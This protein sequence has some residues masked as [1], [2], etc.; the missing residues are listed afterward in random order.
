MIVT[1][2]SKE[3]DGCHNHHFRRRPSLSPS[4]I[5]FAVGLGR[6]A[7]PAARTLRR[8]PPWDDEALTLDEEASWMPRTL[9]PC[10][11]PAR[12]APRAAPT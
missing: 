8:W 12:S 11:V 3:R 10:P 2:M 4:A 6:V 1:I 5:T 9:V 7:G